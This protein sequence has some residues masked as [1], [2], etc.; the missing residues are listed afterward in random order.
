MVEFEDDWPLAFV[1]IE[2]WRPESHTFHLLC[3]EMTITLHDMAYQ[4]GLRIDDDHRVT[5]QVDCEVHLVP[6]NGMQRVGTERHR[7]APVEVHERYRPDNARG[8]GRF[9]HRR[10]LN[11]IGMLNVEWTPYADPQLIGLVPPA[12]VE[13]EAHTKERT[14]T[15]L[16]SHPQQRQMK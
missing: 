14:T 15:P 5:D 3:G 11:G 9:R 10:T 4:L 7:G 12:I 6:Q 8:E 16:S 2:R 1:L 13:V